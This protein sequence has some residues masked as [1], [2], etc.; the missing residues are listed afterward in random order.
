M[1]KAEE[2]QVRLSLQVRIRDRISVLVDELERSP[3]A[4]VAG[5]PTPKFPVA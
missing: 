2:Y 4:E 3:I 1:C 5:P